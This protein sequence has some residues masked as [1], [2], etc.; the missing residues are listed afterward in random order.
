MKKYHEAVLLQESVDALVKDPD[1]IYVDATFGGG[2]H[3]KEII[4]RLNKG[5]LIAFDQDEDA[6]QNAVNDKRFMLI[7]SNYRYIK[8]SLRYHSMIP[9]N[10]VIA[11]LGISSH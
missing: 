3:S 9:I 5:K 8:K 1:G 11:D 2:G 7:K 10:G 6:F 4:K